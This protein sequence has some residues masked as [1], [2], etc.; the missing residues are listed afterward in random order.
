MDELKALWVLAS[1]RARRVLRERV[2]AT[3]RRTVVVALLW[4][5][6]WGLL[7]L[8]F[9]EGWRFLYNQLRILSGSIA[10][11]VWALFFFPLMVMLAFS[12]SV[13]SFSSFFQSEETEFLLSLPMSDG[14]VFAHKAREAAAFSGWATLFIALP[15][16]VSYGRYFAGSLWFYPAAFAAFVPFVLL[17]TAAWIL[18]ALGIGLLAPRRT[19]LLVWGVVFLV[20]VGAWKL[21]QLYQAGKQ[22]AARGEEGLWMREVFDRISALRSDFLPSAWMQETVT[23]AASGDWGT[24]LLY[25]CFVTA[26]ALLLFHLAL[27]AGGRTLRRARMR[28]AASGGGRTIKADGPLARAVRGLLFFLAP[29]EREMILKDIKSFVRSPGQWTQFTVFFGLLAFYI[30]N[31]R[32][33]NY[34]VQSVP[35]RVLVANTNLAALGLVLASFTGRFV[36]PLVSLEGNRIWVL[37]LAPIERRRVIKAKFWFSFLGSSAVSLVLVALSAN[38]LNL[39]RG[40]LLLHAGAML[41]VCFGLSGLAVGLGAL[42][43]MFGEDNP[44]RI[45]S[46]YGGTVNFVL[47]MG[48]MLTVVLLVAVPGQA[49]VSGR[50]GQGTGLLL[51]GGAFLAAAALSVAAGVIPLRA[52]TRAFER[53]EF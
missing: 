29:P 6:F 7:F 14:G 19:K 31:L 32:T 20:G 23:A 5:A 34:H 11:N 51:E 36:F 47:S 39:G 2:F 52:G 16:V 28:V 1:A 30:L 44:S 3:P 41:M 43:P 22:A 40:I 35:W 9:D 48:Y 15:L 27:V 8:L 45:I 46:G 21:L 4:A 25:F 42:F 37:G 38:L 17:S 18:L 53:A 13:I 10:A 50:L 24:W 26:N 33:F 49:A 12:S